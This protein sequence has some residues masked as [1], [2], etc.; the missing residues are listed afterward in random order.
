MYQHLHRIRRVSSHDIMSQPDRDRATDPAA[1]SR[2]YDT[3][4]RTCH[5]CNAA[6]TQS[7]A[8]ITG[9]VLR[10]NGRQF[11]WSA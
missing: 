7:P 4:H 10:K 3:C 2:D 1:T 6:E 5:C 9:D 8:T 11:L